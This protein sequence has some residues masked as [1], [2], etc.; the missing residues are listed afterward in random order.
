MEGIDFDDVRKSFTEAKKKIGKVNIALIGKTGVGK[1]TLINAV[2]KENLAET[3]IG[4]PVTQNF[5]EYTKED[6]YIN[7][8]D[9]KGFELEKYKDILDQLKTIISSRKTQDPATHIHLAWFCINSTSNRIEDAEIKFINEL[10]A[11]IPVIVVL[12]QSINSNKELFNR[13]EIEAPNVSQ[14]VRVLAMDYEI[15]GMGV[16]PA[17]GL[18]NLVEVSFQ[19]IPE[20][21]Q[22][23]F[24][25]A[26]KVSLELKEK[27]A[28]RIIHTS[29]A[30]AAAAC[31]V[32]IPLSDAAM[33]API[34]IGMLAGISHVMGLETTEAFV[35]TLVSSAA[36][37][38]GATY[39]G[40]LIFTNI[41]KL[42]PGVG[43]AAG[44]AVG[45]ATALAI[46]EAMGNAYVSA[47]SYLIENGKSLTSE[48]IAE[49][50]KKLLKQQKV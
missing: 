22:A 11:L 36:G 6:S 17:Y 38:I 49:T 27:S 33:L 25:S 2:F 30:A 14:I 13:I 3:G 7:L 31:A 21:F 26:Q 48:A 18:D 39:A 16:K 20:A 4:R 50:F 8:F 12:T 40:R 28:R 10:G 35:S 1:S 43:S 46:T 32:P 37:V 42:I 24:A 9:T 23:A 29:S 44:A 34:Q 15:E 5:K 19:V 45:A 41:L 47:L